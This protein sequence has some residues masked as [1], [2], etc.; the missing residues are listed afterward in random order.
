MKL[1]FTLVLMLGA[2][3]LGSPLASAQLNPTDLPPSPFSLPAGTEPQSAS[4]SRD[5]GQAMAA[6]LASTNPAV[7][8]LVIE[9]RSLTKQLAGLQH[10]AYQKDPLLLTCDQYID[11]AHEWVMAKHQVE[12]VAA[13]KYFGSATNEIQAAQLRQSENDLSRL[14]HLVLLKELGGNTN[15]APLIKPVF[16]LSVELRKLDTNSAA[17]PDQNYFPYWQCDSMIGYHQTSPPVRTDSFAKILNEL[18]KR[19]PLL[20][21]RVAQIQHDQNVPLDA[22]AGVKYGDLYRTLDGAAEMYLDV[23]TPPELRQQRE[24]LQ[25]KMI[26]LSRLEK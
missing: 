2:G 18:E 12:M 5:A 14:M 8:N 13:D 11:K 25:R 16:D 1:L 15:F 9:I 10:A 6:N 22:V 26:A 4:Y 17:R 3:M 19:Y 23:C 7:R 20:L 21:A 24:D